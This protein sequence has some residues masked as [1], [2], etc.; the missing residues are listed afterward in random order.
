MNRIN[1]IYTKAYS[2]TPAAT[3]VDNELDE[4]IRSDILDG[5]SPDARLT[6]EECLVLM[7]AV[8]SHGEE[9]FM[10]QG[11]GTWKYSYRNP[12]ENDRAEI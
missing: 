9:R 7:Y 2:N 10:Y 8:S 12:K 1:R 6:K 3:A 11:K 5:V 4:T